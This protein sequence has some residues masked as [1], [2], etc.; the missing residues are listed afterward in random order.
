MTV[1]VGSGYPVFEFILPQDCIEEANKVIDDWNELDK[2]TPPASNLVARQTEW[3]L[4]MPKCEEY[5]SECCRMISNLVYNT[6][7]R[8][9]G[10]LHDGTNDL[11]FYA[12][13]IW[14]ADYG[15]GDYTKPHYHYPADFAAVGYLRLDDNAS[16]II[17]DRT[18]PYYPSERQ[19][20][21]FDSKLIHEVPP[22]Q[23]RRRV[24]SM[25]MYKKPG[26]F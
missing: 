11:H 24:F 25:N 9:Y 23:G 3:D 6:G 2:P 19:L 12:K 17:Y 1:F 18:S 7:G 21:I 8:C 22:T 5:V 4:Q 20:L 14:G 16:P 13:N 15:P 10:G 26:T